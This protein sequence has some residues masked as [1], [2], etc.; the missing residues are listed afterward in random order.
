[1]L[2]LYEF[3]LSGNCHKVRLMLSLLGLSYK[4][5]IANGKTGEHKAPEFLSMNP[6]GQ[7]PVLIDG[8]K[9]IR[10]SQA[11]LVYLAVQYGGEK[12]WPK[13][14]N[15]IA[16]ITAWLS[17]CANEV[18]RGPN[19]LRLHYKFGREIAV[20][21]ALQTTTTLLE[22]ME[23]RLSKNQWIASDVLSIADVALYPYIALSPE[24]RV[25]L[26]PFPFVLSW[27]SRI[28]QIPGYVGMPG[29]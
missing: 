14:A 29:I 27:L 9:S 12:W 7:L 15:K 26:T 21:A 5:I 10:D 20:E 19:S 23:V 25:D 2:T 22:V 13:E 11:I 18:A 16:N 24:G 1:M 3:S 28:E 17:T 8:D 4:S 6:F